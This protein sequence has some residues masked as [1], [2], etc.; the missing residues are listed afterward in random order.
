MKQKMM[1]VIVVEPHKHPYVKEI[2]NTLEAKQQIV[3][4]YIQA[5]YP[6]NDLVALVC[7]EEG[8]YHEP[9]W[10]RYVEDYGMIKGTFFICGIT[11]D[12]FCS[13]PDELIEKYTQRFWTPEKIV[14]INNEIII[15]KE[16]I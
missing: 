11:E 6:Y 15:I 3:G 4:G 16:N 2:E 5:I 7:D 12:D 10:N 14:R 1:K 9:D 8:L 13:I